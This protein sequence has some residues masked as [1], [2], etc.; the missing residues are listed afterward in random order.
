MTTNEKNFVIRE[1]ETGYETE[2]PESLAMSFFGAP[3]DF[4][5]ALAGHDKEYSVSEKKAA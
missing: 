1:K 4:K 3:G 5:N 2:L